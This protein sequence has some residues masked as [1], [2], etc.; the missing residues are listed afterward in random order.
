MK[1]NKNS[2]LNNNTSKDRLNELFDDSDKSLDT[3]EIK[4]YMQQYKELEEKYQRNSGRDVGREYS[5]QDADDIAKIYDAQKEVDKESDFRELLE[6]EDFK[7][8]EY[9]DANNTN[10]SEDTDYGNDS[11]NSRN[12]DMD[13]DRPSKTRRNSGRK[14]NIGKRD[15]GSN[16]YE[17]DNRQ[18]DKG[19]YKSTKESGIIDN[20]EEEQDI[21][22]AKRF[23]L[24]LF[25]WLVAIAI[26]GVLFIVIITIFTRGNVDGNSMNPTYQ[27]GEKIW[28]MKQFYTLNKDD[29]IVFWADRTDGGTGNN[30]NALDKL[31]LGKEDISN[32]ELHIKRIVGLPGDD[33]EVRENSVWINGEEVSTSERKNPII[34]NYHLGEDQYFVLGDNTENSLDSRMHGPIEKSSIYGKVLWARPDAEFFP[35]LLHL[36]IFVDF[37]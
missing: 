30:I 31:L 10:N 24:K 26:A 4:R 32:K 27:N 2:D 37:K 1:K 34:R 5:L 8:E 16:E 3:D 17:R 11:D 28:V 35:K 14:N 33:V 18:E 19:H 9:N 12:W 23:I 21:S 29:V 20:L 13:I 6:N 25:D 15:K 36:N 7:V 22:V